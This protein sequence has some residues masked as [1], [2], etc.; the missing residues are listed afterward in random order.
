MQ[1]SPFCADGFGAGLT[2]DDEH[3]ADKH[4]QHSDTKI[5]F[6]ANASSLEFTA[7]RRTERG[8]GYLIVFAFSPSPR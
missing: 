1:R 3:C 7:E 5:G 8:K 6:H 4:R 2:T